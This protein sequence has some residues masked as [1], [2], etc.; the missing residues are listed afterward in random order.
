MTGCCGLGIGRGYDYSGA[1]L[2]FWNDRTVLY[3]GCGV[4]MSCCT[5][6]KTHGTKHIHTQTV[7]FKIKEKIHWA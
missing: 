5:G 4:S 6:A 2:G 7:S 3:V 1:E